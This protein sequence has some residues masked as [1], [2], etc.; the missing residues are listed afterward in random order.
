MTWDV[1]YYDTET[2]VAYRA[3][4]KRLT[5]LDGARLDQQIVDA[6]RATAD[7][8]DFSLLQVAAYVQ[9]GTGEAQRAVFAAPPDDL[10]TDDPAWQPYRPTADELGQMDEVFTQAWY[11]AVLQRNPHRNSLYEALKKSLVLGNSATPS[12][13]SLS[14]SGTNASVS[15]PGISS[16]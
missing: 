6:N 15:E 13:V 16:D 9:N 1:A 2:G 4:A 7:N 11:I 5:M 12:D 10:T 8:V 3:R 14:D